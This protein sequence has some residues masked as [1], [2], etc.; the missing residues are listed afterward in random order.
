MPPPLNRLLFVPLLFLAACASS[1]EK[2]RE[3]VDLGILPPAECEPGTRPAVGKSECAPVGIASCAD[4]FARAAD[5]WGCEAIIAEDGCTGVNRARIGETSCVPDDDCDD[6]AFPPAD[7]DAVV[8]S[9][10]ELTAALAKVPRGGTI[11]LESG[12]YSTIT[13]DHDVKLVGRC[14]AKVRVRGTSSEER[15]IFVTGETT[16]ASIASLAVEGFQGGIVASWGP[17]VD[18]SKVV[19]S[20]NQVGFAAGGVTMRVE[21]AI[22]ETDVETASAASVQAGAKVTLSDVEVRGSAT[23]F[24]AYE[25]DTELTVHRSFVRYVGA[26]NKATMIY[27]YGGAK[28]NVEE[29]L[30][31][32]RAAAI[33][34]V[35]NNLPGTK[36]DAQKS[37]GGSLRIASSELR[38]TGYLRHGMVL[39][40]SKGGSIALEST[41]ILH[42]SDFALMVGDPESSLSAKTSVV[43]SGPSDSSLRSALYVTYGASADMEDTA[44]VGAIGSALMVGHEGSSLNVTRSL[45]AG[46]VFRSGGPNADQGGAGIAIAAGSNGLLSLKDS[47]VVGSEQFGVMLD[48]AAQCTIDSSF[49][50]GTRSVT[51]DDGESGGDSVVV[52]GSAQLTM[53]TSV[54]RGSAGSAVMAVGGEGIIDSSRFV[55]NAIGVHVSQTEVVE[56]KERPAEMP[57]AQLVLVNAVFVDTVG[58]R[59]LDSAIVIPGAPK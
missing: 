52:T 13:I 6:A 32:T 49:F 14:A 18:V 20:G 27:V 26:S 42:E 24:A 25:D 8:H 31:T 7:A 9:S 29:S 55:K 30:I 17:E 3:G 44:V 51:L 53:S 21:K 23:A 59:V 33:A 38:Q 46:T 4:G 5:G 47:A 41:S 43:R 58:D 54:V 34:S 15:G 28:L 57:S 19:L 56:T 2:P 11:A 22:V 1:E 35:G 10:T 37:G 16:K 40:A 12:V 48:E 36:V 39:T 50:D 45:V